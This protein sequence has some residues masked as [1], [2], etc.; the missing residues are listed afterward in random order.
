[1]IFALLW[2]VVGLLC[3]AQMFSGMQNARKSSEITTLKA[4]L[5]GNE[6]IRER[7]LDELQKAERASN[8]TN[9]AIQKFVQEVYYRED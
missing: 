1:M 8:V 5:R 3:I 9:L 6:H 2:T 4:Q 7:L